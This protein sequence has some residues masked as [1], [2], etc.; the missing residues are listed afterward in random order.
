MVY[1]DADEHCEDFS[2]CDD[3]GDYVLLEELD[4]CVHNELAKCT[5]KGQTDQ[6]ECK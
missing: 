4:H 5:Q 2:N 1:D 3:E 6:M